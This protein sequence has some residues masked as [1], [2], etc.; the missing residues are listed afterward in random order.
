MS[1]P[2]ALRFDVKPSARAALGEKCAKLLQKG[3]ALDDQLQVDLVAEAIRC[4][5]H[6]SQE[7]NA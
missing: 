7:S 5:I 3:K 1:I 4:V 2:R 6:S